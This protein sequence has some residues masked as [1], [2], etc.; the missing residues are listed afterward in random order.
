MANRY[1]YYGHSR[2]QM[3]RRMSQL[4]PEDDWDEC[5][6]FIED[7]LCDLVKEITDNTNDDVTSIT[8]M[9]KAFQKE[10][11]RLQ[12]KGLKFF[13]QNVSPNNNLYEN[14]I[15]KNIKKWFKAAYYD[16]AHSDDPQ[17]Q[18]LTQVVLDMLHQVSNGRKYEKL[19]DLLADDRLDW[20]EYLEYMTA[21]ESEIRELAADIAVQDDLEGLALNDLGKIIE[22]EAM[23][24]RRRYG[25]ELF[26]MN[27]PGGDSFYENDV[28]TNIEMWC[29][30][31]CRH[32]AD[33]IFLSLYSNELELTRVLLDMVRQVSS[34]R[35]M[36]LP[37]FNDELYKK[38]IEKYIE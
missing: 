34:W 3:F 28:D 32:A 14:D 25:A 30:M 36:Y 1:G 35:H 12:N 13:K 9:R 18:I 7:V 24:L 23:R 37:E 29:E 11:M 4:L 15:R 10:V 6:E 22:K 27:V 26:F 33:G 17:F 20:D 2:E 5:I 31:R 8:D 19:A 38:Y 16:Y 21:I